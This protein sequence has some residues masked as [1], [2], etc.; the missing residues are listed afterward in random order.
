MDVDLNIS[1]TPCR[2]GARQ[3]LVLLSRVLSLQEPADRHSEGSSSTVRVSLRVPSA[4]SSESYRIQIDM[5]EDW[6]AD[7][8]CLVD[9]RREV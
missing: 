6:A 1:K 5:V 2:L 7:P 3:T 9:I 8:I 4:I